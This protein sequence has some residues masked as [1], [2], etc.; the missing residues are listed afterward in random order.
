[1]ADHGGAGE[2]IEM[3]LRTERA[4]D[5]HRSIHS[6][7]GGLP[8]EHPGRSRNP[9]IKTVGLA[10]LE[11]E[12]PNLARA[13]RFLSDFGFTVADRIPE[14]LVLRGHWAGTPNLVVRRGTGSRFVGP[15]FAADA[16]TDLD[17]L[18]RA[19]P[20]SDRSGA[21]RRS[22]VMSVNVARRRRRHRH[23][24]HRRPRAGP[25]HPAHPRHREV[26]MNVLPTPTSTYRLLRD[27]AYA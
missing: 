1:M 15:A 20:L 24:R 12:K 14:A 11:F 10:W 6:E 21:R 17:R 26:I 19:T 2:T 25:R 18:A 5:P 23:H 13:E 3:E 4:V 7:T 8:G 9:L 22:S 27:A 16:R